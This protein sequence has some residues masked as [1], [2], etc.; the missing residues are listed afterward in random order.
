M[1]DVIFSANC[2]ARVFLQVNFITTRIYQRTLFK[3]YITKA[4]EQTSQFTSDNTKIKPK[5]LPVACLRQ[6]FR[7]ILGLIDLL[8]LARPK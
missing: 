5:K 1:L 3:R 8:G 4:I 6:L 7:V 2:S